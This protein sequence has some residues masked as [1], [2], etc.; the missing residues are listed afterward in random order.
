MLMSGYSDY[1][2]CAEVMSDLLLQSYEDRTTGRTGNN[3]PKNKLIFFLNL[4]FDILLVLAY[5]INSKKKKIIFSLPFR[6]QNLKKDIANIYHL[7]KNCILPVFKE[8]YSFDKYLILH[9]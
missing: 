6:L 4:I 1:G 2:T 3:N 7:S 9:P 8:A 5:F